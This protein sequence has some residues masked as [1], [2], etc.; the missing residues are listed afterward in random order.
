VAKGEGQKVSGFQLYQDI[1]APFRM[2]R[3]E[4]AGVEYGTCVASCNSKCVDAGPRME[5]CHQC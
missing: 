2:R 1:S 3:I 5:V 4:F